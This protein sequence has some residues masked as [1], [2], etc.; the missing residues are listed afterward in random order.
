MQPE[1]PVQ[2]DQDYKVKAEIPFFSGNLGV[3]DFLDWQVEVDRFFEIM[4]IPENKQVKMVS[5]KL[6]STAAYWWDELQGARKR[7]RKVPVQTWRKMKGLLNE[8]FLPRDFCFKNY[9]PKIFEKKLKS[10]EFALRV[11]GNCLPEEKIENFSI[12]EAPQEIIHDEEVIKYEIARVD[13]VINNE[14][15]L[16]P[17]INHSEPDVIQEC[18][19]ESQEESTTVAYESQN[20]Y[21][22]LIYGVGF[23]IVPSEY[24]EDLVNNP[25]VQLSNFFLGLLNA[26]SCLLF[27][28]NSRASSFI[29]EENDVGREWTRFNQKTIKVK[30]RHRIKKSDWKI[31]NSRV[32]RLLAA[33]IFKKNWFW[34]F[35]VSRAKSQ[36][37]ILNQI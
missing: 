37:L 29:V 28:R 10:K 4:E 36:V 27:K 5:R 34:T 35:R 20:A 33:G 1:Q 6:K 30:K 22:R 16:E 7:R 9:P 15:V 11:E 18:N 26:Y 8:K 31:G 3:E 14:E 19:L 25:Q 13:M 12:E 17:E 2:A 21:D 24:A 23:M 32:K